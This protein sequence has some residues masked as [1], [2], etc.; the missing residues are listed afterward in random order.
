M[1]TCLSKKKE[2]STSTNSLVETKSTITTSVEFEWKNN[3][4][5][6]NGITVSKPE[7]KTQTEVKL[8]KENNKKHVDSVQEH[9]GQVK[10]EIFIIKH[11]KSHD[12]K[13]RNSSIEDSELMGMRTS[14]CTKE[15][16][17]AILIHCGRLS[18]NSSGKASSFREQRRRFSSSKTSNDF[19][20]F[21]NDAISSEKDQKI[22][23]FY[24]DGDW[25]EPAEKLHQHLQSSRSLSMD[26]NRRRTPSRE[27]E[28]QQ[29]SSS[30]ER[31][32]S[33]SPVRR[34]SDT[35]TTLNSRNNTN[36]SSKPAKMVS[37]PATVTSLVM[38][39]S[40]NNGC[41]GGE[42]AAATAG[43]R[44][45]TVRRNVGSPRF[46][47]PARGNGNAV[48]QQQELSFSRNSSSRKKEESPYRRNPLSELESNSLSIPHSTTN[49]NSSWVQNRSK[50][51]VETEDNQVST[52]P[53]HHF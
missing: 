3:S 19:D 34:C 52:L 6:K 7:L 39:K 10:K 40:Y 14:S 49:Y 37:V 1:G 26:R 13:D 4:S 27:R 36:T 32:V 5:C 20:K 45:I 42:S 11:R 47:S 38:D 9:K 48:N 50:M 23:G 18:R 29:C 41:G 15:D 44:R 24:E 16:V 21:D 35:T 8:K 43:I 33:I 17:D 51:E 25:K 31:R 28:Q 46:Q 22:S 53:Q 12:D 30:R 2:S